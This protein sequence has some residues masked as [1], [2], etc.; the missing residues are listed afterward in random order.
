M[1]PPDALESVESNIDREF[2]EVIYRQTLMKSKLDEEG[3]IE[4]AVGGDGQIQ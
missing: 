3:D 1:F 4:I 2:A